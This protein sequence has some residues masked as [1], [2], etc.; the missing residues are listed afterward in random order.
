LKVGHKF[1]IGTALLAFSGVAG[2]CTDIAVLRNGFSI[3]HQ[4][5][6]QRGS[7]TRLYLEKTH[8]NYVDVLTADVVGFETEDSPSPQA[9]PVR[10]SQSLDEL[11]RAVGSQNNIDPDLINSVIR[12]ESGFNANAVSPKGA[13]GLMQLMPQT[14]I[15]LGVKDVMDPE[16]NVEAGTRYLREL[17]SRYHDDL[18][19]ALAAYNA[20][21]RR[22]EQ[23]H[24]VP[25]YSET[26][27]FVAQILNDFHRKK[28]AE[29]RADLAA[30]R[31][32]VDQ[33]PGGVAVRRETSK[34]DH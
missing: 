28:R 20:G 10:R 26:Q 18:I 9:S 6:E 31:K 21:P 1:A 24:G 33:R 7:Q 16:A 3:Q 12:A 8:E 29:S 25:P 23:Y 2:S 13:Q 30:A 17:L 5:R 15:W 4:Q 11:V 34:S 32:R 22:V 14:A 27:S 19:K